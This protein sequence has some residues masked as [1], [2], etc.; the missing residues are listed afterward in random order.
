[1][2]SPTPSTPTTSS[3]HR[4]RVCPRRPRCRLCHRSAVPACSTSRTPRPTGWRACWRPEPGRC[5]ASRCPWGPSTPYDAPVHPGGPGTVAALA[6][7]GLP[8]GCSA[9]DHRSPSLRSRSSRSGHRTTAPTPM[10]ALSTRTR[11]GRTAATSRPSPCRSRPSPDSCFVGRPA[12]RP[13]GPSP[14]GRTR[15]TPAGRGRQSRPVTPYPKP[16]GGRLPG[17]PR[18]LSPVGRLSPGGVPSPRLRGVAARTPAPAGRARPRSD[19]A[20]GRHVSS[21]CRTGRG[22]RPT[23]LAQP[24][25]R[26]PVL[27]PGACSTPSRSLR[28]PRYRPTSLPFR[29]Q[30]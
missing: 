11:A 28:P 19:P 12:R 25:P 8:R 2:P 22:R 14:A 30:P 7:C 18:P 6:G 24:P 17:G 5:E 16:W 9:R 29:D 10:A 13:A 27:P 15:G 1:M 20:C 23:G 26:P 3:R 21:S 4:R